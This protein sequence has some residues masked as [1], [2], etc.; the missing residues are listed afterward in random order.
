MLIG[1]CDDF[2]AIHSQI[3]DSV[4]ENLKKEISFVDFMDGRELVEYPGEMDALFLDIDMPGLDGIE[5]GR[6]LRKKQFSGKIILLTSVKERA[7]EG[8]EIEV[9]RYLPKPIDEKKLIKIVTE[10]L[11]SFAGTETAKLYADGEAYQIPQRNISYIMR[12]AHSSQT[13][14]IVGSKTF[15]SKM[16]ISEWAQFLDETLFCQTHRSYIVNLKMVKDVRDKEL[17]LTSGEKIPVSR[18]EKTK[19]KRK[20]MEFYTDFR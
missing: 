3:K 2:E 7:A 12:P 20:F 14:A 4:R 8:Y 9:Y 6:I 19:V 10:V 11:Q 15:H 18:R 5:A 17:L 13:E 16:S 1:I